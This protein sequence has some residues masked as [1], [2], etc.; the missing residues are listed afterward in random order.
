MNP[1]LREPGVLIGDMYGIQSAQVCPAEQLRGGNDITWLFR[2]SYHVA[3]VCVPMLRFLPES[4]LSL[5]SF[6]ATH[7]VLL[8]LPSFFFFFEKVGPSWGRYS[9]SLRFSVFD[10]Q[11]ENAKLVFAR[12]G[13]YV[14]AAARILLLSC[15]G[16][17]Q[18]YVSWQT[19]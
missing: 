17:C 13:C 4:N 15:I 9:R 2:S 11:S 3:L 5:V 12:A 14:F 10:S 1:S 18:E 7:H 19:P 16:E 6:L 8:L